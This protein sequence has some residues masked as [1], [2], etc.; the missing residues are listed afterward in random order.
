MLITSK[1]VKET[2]KYMVVKEA[3]LFLEMIKQGFFSEMIRFSEAQV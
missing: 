3:T 2:I 1:E